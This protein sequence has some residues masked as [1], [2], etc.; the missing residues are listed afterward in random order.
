MEELTVRIYCWTM[1]GFLTYK[2]YIGLILCVELLLCNS[3]LWLQCLTQ[4]GKWTVY[5]GI[6]TIN[7]WPIWNVRDF[8]CLLNNYLWCKWALGKVFVCS[9]NVMGFPLKGDKVILLFLCRKTICI[10]YVG[11]DDS[12]PGNSLFMCV[13]DREY[14]GDIH[15]LNVCNMTWN[16]VVL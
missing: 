1:Y 2:L 8:L 9:R 15:V 6:R 5:L 14:L 12:I 16:L 11:V 10:L 7:W 3:I 13:I 4:N